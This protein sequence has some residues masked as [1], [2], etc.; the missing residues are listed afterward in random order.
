MVRRAAAKFSACVPGVGSI[1]ALTL[2]AGCWFGVGAAAPA[3]TSVLPG[4]ASGDTPKPVGVALWIVDAATLSGSE[5]LAGDRQP[6]LT[7]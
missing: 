5:C 3:A 6:Q 1:E 4:L 2:A 7:Q